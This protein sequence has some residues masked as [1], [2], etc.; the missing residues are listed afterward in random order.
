[1]HRCGD[2]QPRRRGGRL[3]FQ[4]CK[5]VVPMDGPTLVAQLDKWLRLE[6]WGDMGRYGEIQLGEIQLD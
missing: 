3:L 1:M 5:E 6:I 2:A 4:P